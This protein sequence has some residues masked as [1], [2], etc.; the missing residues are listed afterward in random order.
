MAKSTRRPTP[1]KKSTLRNSRATVSGPAAP[2][3]SGTGDAPAE[4]MSGTQDV[5]SAFPFNPIKSAE[6]DPD[7]ALTPLEGPSVKPADPIV[8]RAP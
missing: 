8:G 1:P 3:S 7:A 6:Y 2:D 4:K 5:A